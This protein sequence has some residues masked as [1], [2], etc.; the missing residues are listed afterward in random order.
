MAN[1]AS[2]TSTDEIKVTPRLA[3]PGIFGIAVLVA[4][5]YYSGM[6]YSTDPRLVFGFAGAL[7]LLGI[8]H[9]IPQLKFGVAHAFYLYTYHWLLAFLLIFI[10]P[11]LSFY[12]Y[13]RVLLLYL[14]EYYYGKK[15][16]IISSLAMLTTMLVG[17][18]YQYDLNRQ[19]GVR[20]F[21]LFAVLMLVN[22]IMTDMGM[23]NRR[24]RTDTIK[25]VV[26]AEYEHDRLVALINSMSDAVIATDD[27]GVIITYNAA[28][29]DILDTNATLTGETITDYL[30]PYTVEDK[31]GQYSG[32]CQEKLTIYRGEPI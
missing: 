9:L 6:T 7:A 32:C 17:S 30:K 14:S 13:A 19:L 16:T 24:K 3:I 1:S 25:K 22:K 31:P 5:N 21:A 15:G 11:T 26:H 8:S 27:Q 23:G 29:L 4:I 2:V 18:I 20:I 28:A 12:L 10:V